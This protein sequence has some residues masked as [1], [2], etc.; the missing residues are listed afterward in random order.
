MI[1]ENTQKMFSSAFMM[2][3]APALES[4]PRREP[5]RELIDTPEV[6][7]L[8]EYEPDEDEAGDMGP[9]GMDDI[10]EAEVIDEKKAEEHLAKNP[11]KLPTTDNHK[12]LTEVGVLKKQLSALMGKESGETEYSRILSMYKVEHCNEI[13]DDKA[14]KMF[15]RELREFV[16]TIKSELHSKEGG[17]EG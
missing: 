2:E 9:V 7:M 1:L 16:E 8:P 3:P 17:D 12:F 5:P 15:Y 10:P 6:R 13:V 4:G 14:Q 11:P